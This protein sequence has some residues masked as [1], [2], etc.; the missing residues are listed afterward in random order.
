MLPAHPTP[1]RRHRK[2]TNVSTLTGLK[3]RN[4]LNRSQTTVLKYITG[5]PPLLPSN[6]DFVQTFSH[7]RSALTNLGGKLVYS[8]SISVTFM[9]E[10]QNPYKKAGCKIFTNSYKNIN[11]NKLISSTCLYCSSVYPDVLMHPENTIRP[12]QRTLSFIRHCPSL[13]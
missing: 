6:M 9:H 4:I 8:E 10:K 5:F 2:V 13:L 12:K 3:K 11:M 7:Q 1:R